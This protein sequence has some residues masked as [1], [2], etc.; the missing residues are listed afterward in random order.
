MSFLASGVLLF[1]QNSAKQWNEGQNSTEGDSIK[2]EK[3]RKRL[4]CV[5]DTII[6]LVQLISTWPW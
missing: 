3:E 5:T 6:V 1:E 4:G 2:P